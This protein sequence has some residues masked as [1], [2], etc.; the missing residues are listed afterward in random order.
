MSN[1]DLT[2]AVKAEFPQSAFDARHCLVVPHAAEERET[3]Q[4]Q[5]VHPAQGKGDGHAR[6]D[7]SRRV[8]KRPPSG[9]GFRGAETGRRCGRRA[10]ARAGV[11]LLYRPGPLQAD[12][13]QRVPRVR[14][15]EPSRHDRR[16]EVRAARALEH[17]TQHADVSLIPMDRMSPQA[18]LR[19]MSGIRS[20]DTGPELEL[21][22]ALRAGGA[23]G[24][25]TNAG[26]ARATSDILF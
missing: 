25:R 7:G 11:V 16:P 17:L 4:D 2:R 18:R 22:P 20:R 5:G 6:R 15:G 1:E 26:A 21:C 14:P 12:L 3:H 10:L 9:G 23:P 13:R 8:L 19:V 24:F